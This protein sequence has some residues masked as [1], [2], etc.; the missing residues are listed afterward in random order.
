MS[1]KTASDRVAEGRAI[2]MSLVCISL[3]GIVA[4]FIDY[5]KEYNRLALIEK[6]GPEAIRA[7]DTLEE[8]I[9]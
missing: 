2:M 6:M 1:D 4:L 3:L 8:E 7:L 9:Q 5:V